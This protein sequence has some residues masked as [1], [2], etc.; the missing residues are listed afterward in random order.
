MGN[1][2]HSSFTPESLH[3]KTNYNPKTDFQDI[4]LLFRK[5]NSM[6]K[7]WT[8]F[9]FALIQYF[10]FTFTAKQFVR[11]HLQL[12]ASTCFTTANPSTTHKE[13]T[14]HEQ[15]TK[16]SSNSQKII[17]FSSL[18]SSR[19]LE[20][21]LEFQIYKNLPPPSPW[22]V[23]HCP[24]CYWVARKVTQHHQPRKEL[25]CIAPRGF[26]GPCDLHQE[27]LFTF[28]KLVKQNWLFFANIL[29]VMIYRLLI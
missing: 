3:A 15:I 21:F 16:I 18:S 14:W 17:I 23:K 1:I 11:P 10:A 2:H 24:V 9:L 12:H 26:G 25:P 29:W 19:K 13:S 22:N 4:F 20:Y 5:N 7:P 8:T 6:F 27:T 28:L